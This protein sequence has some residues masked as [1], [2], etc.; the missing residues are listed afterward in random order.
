MEHFGDKSLILLASEDKFVTVNRPAALLLE[1]MQET[2]AA[3]S[4]GLGD[5]VAL[6]CARYELTEMQASSEASDLLFS[7]T[8]H[9]ILAVQ[10]FADDTGAI[11]E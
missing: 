1:L 9:G 3:G 7:W 8:E 5:L 10:D 2:F 11:Y 6:F 4:F